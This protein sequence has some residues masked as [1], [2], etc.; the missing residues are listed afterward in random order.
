MLSQLGLVLGVKVNE[1]FALVL[2]MW[3]L[4]TLSLA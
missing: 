3:F 2:H 1:A 4:S